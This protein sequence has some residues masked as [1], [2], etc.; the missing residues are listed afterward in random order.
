LYNQTPNTL[1]KTVE[2]IKNIIVK[3]LIAYSRRLKFSRTNARY[4]AAK[5][6][7]IAAPLEE[8]IKYE[9]TDTPKKNKE[10]TINFRRFSSN[11]KIKTEKTSPN[12]S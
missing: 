3:Q 11:I 10:K 1:T 12:F 5:K 4:T 2:N 6:A 8:S 7:E 9:K